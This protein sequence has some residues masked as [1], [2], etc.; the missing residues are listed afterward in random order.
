MKREKVRNYND[1]FF[2]A[3][4]SQTQMLAAWKGYESERSDARTPPP[5]SCSV[6][7]KGKMTRQVRREVA[8]L[9]DRRDEG[10]TPFSES[11][12]PI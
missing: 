11:I 1:T 3:I 10:D 5:S 12:P 9:S 6:K 2:N 4:V 8:F 7:C